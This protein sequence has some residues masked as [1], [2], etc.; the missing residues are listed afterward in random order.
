MMVADKREL[1]EEIKSDMMIQSLTKKKVKSK[2]QTQMASQTK[3]FTSWRL[4]TFNMHFET[5]K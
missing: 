2:E 5:V 4:I 3:S 1:A